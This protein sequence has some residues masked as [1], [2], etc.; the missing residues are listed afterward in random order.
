MSKKWFLAL[1]IF[2]CSTVIGSSLA[3]R[4]SSI[5]ACNV[6][7]FGNVKLKLQETFID[8]ESR[9]QLAAVDEKINIT[10]AAHQERRF[11]VENTGENPLYTRV[12]FSV[13]GKREDGQ[14]FSTKEYLEIRTE[15][16]NWIFDD[17]WYYYGW[18]V[19]PGQK[20]AP[21]ETEIDFFVDELTKEYPGS[22]FQLGIHAQGIQSQN[23]GEEAL[24]AQGWPEEERL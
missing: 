4:T 15:P 21:L 13:Q 22:E 12:R 19:E 3:F 9:E 16:G 1:S 17:G 23:N 18:V 7:T 20:T 14:R 8:E 10:S 24:E 2:L 5:T 6:V 11:Y